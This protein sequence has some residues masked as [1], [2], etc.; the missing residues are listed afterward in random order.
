[1]NKGNY[2]YVSNVCMMNQAL[3]QTTMETWNGDPSLGA[4]YFNKTYWNRYM[5][6]MGYND[7]SAFV[8]QYLTINDIVPPKLLGYKSEYGAILKWEF[9]HIELTAAVAV[10]LGILSFDELIDAGLE[11][12]K[13]S[14]KSVTYELKYYIVDKYNYMTPFPCLKKI[15]GSDTTAYP[16][17]YYCFYKVG[18][19]DPYDITNFPML[20][21]P[22]FMS[23]GYNPKSGLYDVHGQEDF[24]FLN[25]TMLARCSCPL[26]PFLE[27]DIIGRPT[28]KLDKYACN[29]QK[30]FSSLAFFPKA[31]FA[32]SSEPFNYWLF[33]PGV[34]PVDCMPYNKTCNAGEYNLYVKLPACPDFAAPNA[35]TGIFLIFNS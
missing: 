26:V 10:N 29:E 4:S 35:T 21:V 12:I 7:Y 31:D 8:R 9:D 20:A 5:R 16:F 22:S 1:M 25:D 30:F 23:M 18:N 15:D 32:E 14:Y 24:Y 2:R 3:F 11:S 17:E 28:G 19:F 33:Y 27:F 6:G 13:G 34:D